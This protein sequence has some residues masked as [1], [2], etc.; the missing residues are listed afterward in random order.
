LDATGV[1]PY[2]E[3]G[4]RGG[5]TLFSRTADILLRTFS[6]SSRNLSLSGNLPS[7]IHERLRIRKALGS[8]LI[9][10]SSCKVPFCAM[11]DQSLAVLN[12]LVYQYAGLHLQLV[13]FI[14]CNLLGVT[15][16]GGPVCKH[17]EVFLFVVVFHELFYLRLLLRTQLLCLQL[18]CPRLL[19]TRVLCTSLL[20]SGLLNTRLLFTLLRFSL[21]LPRH[22]NESR[23]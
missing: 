13:S 18:L 21:A 16:L 6:C 8:E 7:D 9:L 3:I 2:L 14:G 17:P 11:E 19:C 23:T 12:S 22:H 10:V 20:G 15:L 5:G 1:S 4:Q